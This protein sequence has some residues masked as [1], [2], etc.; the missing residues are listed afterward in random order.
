MCLQIISPLP[1][2]WG[3]VLHLIFFSYMFYIPNRNGRFDHHNSLRLI[4]KNLLN[5]I[6][7][8]T[9]IKEILLLI[10]I[11][12][13][14][15]HDIRFISIFSGIMSTAVTSL[16]WANSIAFAKPTYPSP[17]TVIFICMCSL[18]IHQNCNS[19]I[20]CSVSPYGWLFPNSSVVP[21]T[22]PLTPFGA[23]SR[24]LSALQA[25]SQ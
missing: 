6:L 7:N 10:I 13:R 23:N 17:M 15:Y 11:R 9:C 4:Q 5:C 1:P 2:L 12:R 19:R 18:L 22:N 3:S 16:C 14:S 24:I 21:S 8:R 20:F 25:P